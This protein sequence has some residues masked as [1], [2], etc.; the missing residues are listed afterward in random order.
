MQLLLR[1]PV[2][3]EESVAISFK[4]EQY[5]LG[6]LDEMSLADMRDDFFVNREKPGQLTGYETFVLAIFIA[7]TMGIDKANIP[8]DN[9]FASIEKRLKI[10]LEEKFP[11]L[12]FQTM[13]S[14]NRVSIDIVGF[15]SASFSQLSEERKMFLA[16]IYQTNEMFSATLH[17]HCSRQV[18][19]ETKDRIIA[20]HRQLSVSEAD[21]VIAEM[22]NLVRQVNEEAENECN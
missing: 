1:S 13:Y 14:I 2:C 20:A 12:D 9:C 21:R 19:L 3:Q 11:H 5:S 10:R 18:M 16:G 17:R 15:D 6:V 7:E 22:E 4:K 8:S